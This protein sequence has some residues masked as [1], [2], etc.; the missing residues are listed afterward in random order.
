MS[1]SDQIFA[2]ADIPAAVPVECPEWGCTLYARCLTALE[3]AQLGKWTKEG[4]EADGAIKSVIAAI[5]DDNG[6][7]VF[8]P[9]HLDAL[10][11]KSNVVIRRLNAAINRLNGN[12][13]AEKN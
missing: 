1:L 12:E 5:V 7:P 13:D 11:G 2:A 6:K 8:T 4:D 3:L 9:A 10:R